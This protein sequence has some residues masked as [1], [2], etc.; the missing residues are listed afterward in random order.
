VPRI[1]QKVRKMIRS[2]SGNDR[3]ASVLKGIAS[4]AARETAPRIPDQEI[5][6]E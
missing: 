1:T 3:P 2:R 4:A 6:N 5:R